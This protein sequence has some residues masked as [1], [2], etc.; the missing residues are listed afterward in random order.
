MSLS[1]KETLTLLIGNELDKNE[2]YLK[3]GKATDIELNTFTFTFTPNDQGAAVE[4]VRLKSIQTPGGGSFVIVPEQDSFVTVGFFSQTT[5][6]C[7]HVELAA[8][9]TL[10]AGTFTINGG[11]NGGLIN[12]NELTDKLNGL[13]KTVNDF[14]TTF[15]SHTHPGVQPGGGVSGIP[16]TSPSPAAAFNA[17]DYED[18][19]VTH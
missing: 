16:T 4:G 6:I 19:T 5:A 13:Q 14:I 9:I 10:E 2:F 8:S 18:S 17:S 15:S 3:T 7:L 1:I 12:I 11:N